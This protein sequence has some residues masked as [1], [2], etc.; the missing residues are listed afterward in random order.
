VG[1][2]W[3]QADGSEW[4]ATERK[5]QA[6]NLMLDGVEDINW[7]D[8]LVKGTSEQLEKGYFRLTSAPDPSSVRPEPVLAK[9]LERLVGLLR[10]G[11]VTYF[12]A[13][14]QFKGMRQDCTVQHLRNELTARI[15]EAHARAALEYGDVAEYN[16]VSG[17]PLGLLARACH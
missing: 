3:F 4:A 9:A 14:D 16:Q 8:L 12:Y 7:D 1:C 17:A 5:R 15:Y 11:S 6:A 2:S 13:Q 10:A